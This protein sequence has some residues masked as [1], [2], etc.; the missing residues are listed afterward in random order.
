[1]ADASHRMRFRE[2]GPPLAAL[3]ALPLLMFR[4]LL[5]RGEALFERDIHLDWYT[6]A[7]SFVRA[8]SNGWPLWDP[9]FSFGQPLLADPSA[10]VAYPFTWLNLVVRPWTY[11]TLLVV[12]HLMSGAAGTYLLGRK[13]GLSAWGAFLAGAVWVLSGPTLS[14]ANLWHH[15]ASASWIPWVLLAAE[16]TLATRRPRHALL[17]GGAMAAQIV[18]GSSEVCA[19]TGLLVGLLACA[20]VEW[21]RPLAQGNRALAGLGLLGIAFALGLSAIQWLPTVEVARRSARWELG[22]EARV[23]WSVH[24]KR[25]IQLAWPVS[26]NDVPL[27]PARRAEL[28]SGREPFLFSH[29][30]GLPVLGLVGACALAA[31]RRVL[32]LALALA[33]ALLV[34]LGRHGFAY[35]AVVRLVPPL[36]IFRYPEKLLIVTSVLWALLAGIGF[37]AWLAPGRVP[38]RFWVV[39][40]GPLVVAVALSMAWLAVPPSRDSLLGL[41][42][43]QAGRVLGAAAA[44]LGVLLVA[45]WRAR[46]ENAGALLPFAVAG[47][48]V[49]DLAR[50]SSFLNPSVPASF[51]QIRPPTL[52]VLR[53]DDHRRL[54]VAEYLSSPGKSEQRLGRAEPY[55]VARYVDGW[56]PRASA[57]LAMRLYL[58]PPAA[59]AWGLEGSYEI[60]ARGLYPSPLAALTR[61]ALATEGQ[62]VFTRLLQLGA[63]G[64]AL[65]LGPLQ[66]DLTPLGRY[67]ALLVDPVRVFQ[68]PQALPRAYVVGTA[69]VA[70]DREALAR[71]VD[72]AFEPA[73]EVV[74]ASGPEASAGAAF[75]GSCR[76]EELA[77]DRARLTAELSEPGYVVLVDAFDPGWRARVD[78]DPEP[79]LRANVAFRAVR[80][81]AG[82]HTIE[83][84]YWPDTLWPALC[85]TSLALLVALGVLARGAVRGR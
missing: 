7:E 25:L 65:A 14:L 69:R 31:H 81:P 62:P 38:R 22:R 63:V 42:A 24:P 36:G 16:Q 45:L 39:V 77:G 79:V 40:V 75:S 54:Y 30:L 10:M 11:Y 48:V 64:K 41:L 6:Q 68:V 33:A 52:E 53:Q 84:R 26:W 72:P 32:L 5:F 78:G 56:D 19:M 67:D 8:A 60:D 37:D 55:R 61:V 85:M 58:V 27:T 66:E 9:S 46:R 23:F 59:G 43:P 44:T 29:Y 13:L 3:L 74:I 35:D 21:R 20:H 57:A 34:A 70:P 4:S 1:M 50:A 2:H 18:A 51:Y 17:W 12:G 15:F 47:L 76:I 73:R 28:F 80:V 83:Y 71:L 82:R 49:V